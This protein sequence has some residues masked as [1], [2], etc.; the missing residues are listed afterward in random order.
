M[1]QFITPDQARAIVL[2]QVAPLPPETIPHAEALG[3]VLAREIVSPVAL[4]PF[5]NSAMDG[6][7]L[8]AD[9][10]QNAGKNAPARLRVL[11][12]IA[13]GDVPQQSVESGSCAK[14]MTG[15]LLPKGADAVV[16]REETDDGAEDVEIFRSARRG[17]NIRRAGEE[18]ARGETIFESGTLVRP[19]EW[20]LL[21][22]LEQAQIE[23]FRRPRV[24]LIVTGE[25][26]VELGARRCKTGKS[27]IPIPTHLK[28]WRF[29]A[30]RRLAKPNVLATMW[31]R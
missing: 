7:A 15:A 13:A 25:E 19:A 14:I 16:M 12:T 24:A 21:A 11:E 28:V 23:V 8:C 29:R 6:Y 26:L 2:E 4:P 27:A 18:I 9:D 20:G 22:S 1:L 3:R 17:Q 30:A 5:D 31:K 10:L